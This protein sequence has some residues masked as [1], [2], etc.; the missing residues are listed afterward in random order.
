MITFDPVPPQCCSPES[1]R[2][3]RP[4]RGS[5]QQQTEANSTFQIKNKKNHPFCG[6]ELKMKMSGWDGCEITHQAWKRSYVQ[7][8]NPT[9]VGVHL[10][11]QN[12]R[13]RFVNAD[14]ASA[15]ARHHRTFPQFDRWAAHPGTIREHDHRGREWTRNWG[16]IWSKVGLLGSTR[17]N[18]ET[19]EA[20]K[21]HYVRTNDVWG[22][23]E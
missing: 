5:P 1:L 18:E 17:V 8:V 4:W 7:G 21:E 9:S 22:K 3:A 2:G 14:L 16:F 15:V 23:L 19:N 11:V 12:S 20:R 13:H 10:R 6:H